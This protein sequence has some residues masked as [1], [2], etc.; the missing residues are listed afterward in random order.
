[1]P[2]AE[3]T[4]ALRKLV[5]LAEEEKLQAA[6]DLETLGELQRMSGEETVTM[7]VPEVPGGVSNMEDLTKLVTWFAV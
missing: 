5:A 2:S 6:S 1:L 4:S 3:Q 7:A